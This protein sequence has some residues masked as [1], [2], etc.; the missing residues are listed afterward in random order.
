MA[1]L[2]AAPR[3]GG[4]RS[5]ARASILGCLLGVLAMPNAVAARNPNDRKGQHDERRSAAR[6][7][8]RGQ[9]QLRWPICRVCIVCRDVRRGRHERRSGRVCQGSPDEPDRARQR[10]HAVGGVAAQGNAKSGLFPFSGPLIS[11]NG[12]LVVFMSRATNLVAG[13]TNGAGDVFVHDRQTKLTRRV[14]LSASGLQL[15]GESLCEAISNDARFLT[16]RKSSPNVILGVSGTHVYRVNLETSAVK[17]V[18]RNS[19]GGPANGNS[20]DSAISADGR[21]VAFVSLADNLDLDVADTNL[22][23]DVFVRD[24]QVGTRRASAWTTRDCR[25]FWARAPMPAQPGH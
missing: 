20:E 15:A 25:S 22:L 6:R 23:A 24:M 21:H 5:T 17:L 19:N 12:R 11:G 10:R 8:R 7:N 4:L 2:N 1:L 18:S 16:F 13:D 3:V 9:H 14:S